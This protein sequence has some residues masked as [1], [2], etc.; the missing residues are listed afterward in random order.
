MVKYLF[1]DGTSGVK[2]VQSQE[3]LQSLIAAST[4]QDKIRIWIFNTSEWVSYSAFSKITQDNKTKV[5]ASRSND[6]PGQTSRAYPAKGTINHRQWLKK[7]LVFG[8]SGA[9][10]FLVY[11]FSKLKWQVATPL[12]ISAGRPANVPILNADSIIQV[13]EEIRGQKL[14]KTTRTNLRIRNTWPDRILLQLTSGRDTNNSVTKYHS[15][16][17][18]IDNTTGYNIDQAI[19]KLA[20]WSK[21]MIKNTDTFHFNNIS[22]AMPSSKGVDNHYQG[23][24][25]SVSFQLIRAK[26]FNFCYSD[27]KKSNYGSVNDRWFCRE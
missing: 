18:S 21:G 23:D 8:I 10:I 14:D 15:I 13:L 19:V 1:T 22:Y 6:S 26:A 24:S 16:G 3:E 2:E 7:F 4:R 17:L 27:D 25:I 20:I 12:T 9:A 11:N 5:V